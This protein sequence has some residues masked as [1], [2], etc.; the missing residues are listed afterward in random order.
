[1][2]AKMLKLLVCG[3]IISD[4]ELNEEFTIWHEDEKLKFIQSLFEIPSQMLKIE[5]RSTSK[6]LK[7]YFHVIASLLDFILKS[8]LYVFKGIMT[9]PMEIRINFPSYLSQIMHFHLN[10]VKP[11]TYLGMLHTSYT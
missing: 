1:M 6:L 10:V 11:L 9:I 4:K 5:L 2:I 3:N 8:Y 7:S